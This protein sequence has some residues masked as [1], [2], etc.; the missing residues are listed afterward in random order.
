MPTNF[1]RLVNSQQGQSIIN[2]LTNIRGHLFVNHTN[3]GKFSY[4]TALPSDVPN[5]FNFIANNGSIT[6]GTMPCY[7]S[8]NIPV[9]NQETIQ[10]PQGYYSGVT[11]ISCQ[12]GSSA[13]V[14]NENTSVTNLFGKSVEIDADVTNCAQLFTRMSFNQAVVFK[15]NMVTNCAMMFQDCYYFNQPVTIPNSVTICWAMFR[16]CAN[17]NQPM[18][19]PDLVTRCDSMYANCAN[20]NSL[21]TISTSAI[22]CYYMFDRCPKFNQP[23]ILTNSVT[24]C[25]YMFNGCNTFNQP[26]TIPNSVTNCAYMF[27]YCNNQNCPIHVPSRFNSN[28]GVRG[29]H[30]NA[31]NC[32][33][34]Y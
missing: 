26:I 16:N 22:N 15:G 28:N 24:N 9:G 34:W 32:I 6:R 14:I 10:I 19:I 4:V 1:D 17:L 12:S 23:I 27:A 11:S 13:I 5:A 31:N 3:A 25:Y 18:N 30:S 8:A 21:V 2:C 7:N 29:W 33:V 20:L